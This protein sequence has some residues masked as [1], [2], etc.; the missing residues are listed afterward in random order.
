MVL[1]ASH[2]RNSRVWLE[3]ERLARNIR[4]RCLIV[5][6][7]AS[8]VL[9]DRSYSRPVVGAGLDC[10]RVTKLHVRI[11][12]ESLDEHSVLRD[13]FGALRQLLGADLSLTIEVAGISVNFPALHESS[14]QT[15]A[16]TAHPAPTGDPPE[17]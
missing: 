8:W 14:G 3:R 2:V 6:A 15:P 1:R 17:T 7:M 16:L 12:A 11:I 9:A 13:R 10:E 4:Q 5:R